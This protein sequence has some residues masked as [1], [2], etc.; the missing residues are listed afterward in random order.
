MTAGSPRRDLPRLPLTHV[1]LYQVCCGLDALKALARVAPG[2]GDGVV[3][4]NELVA[5][6]RKGLPT[7]STFS[8]MEGLVGPASRQ[9]EVGETWPPA[10]HRQDQGGIARC[11]AQSL[12][13]S[14]A[15]R[16]E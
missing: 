1:L 5:A 2:P 4:I 8:G 11:G 13:Q 15:G 16:L 7:C 14:L 12:R 6:L 3:S 10:S 9:T